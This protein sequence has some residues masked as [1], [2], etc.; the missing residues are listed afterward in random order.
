MRFTSL[1][2][3]YYWSIPLN[4][5]SC[6]VSAHF[7]LYRSGWICYPPWTSW[8]ELVPQAKLAF[9]DEESSNF[10]LSQLSNNWLIW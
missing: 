8:T 4:L 5:V 3:L 10:R 1:S 7:Y 9:D 2:R 6:F